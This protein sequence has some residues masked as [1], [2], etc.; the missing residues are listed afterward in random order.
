MSSQKH[1]TSLQ[2]C[3]YLPTIAPNSGLALPD[4]VPVHQHFSTD[5]IEDI[6]QETRTQ[7]ALLSETDLRGKQIAI[8]AGSRGIKG[9]VETLKAIVAQLKAWEAKPF[10]V[11]AMGSHGGATASGQVEVLESLGITENSIGAP[12]RSSMEIVELGK[13]DRNTVVCCDRLAFESDGIIVCNRVKAH[14]GFLGDYESGLLKMMAI[15]L[16]KHIGTTSLH[17]L[18][19][20]QFHRVIPE[21]AALFLEKAPIL[22]GV[23]I[24]E[25][26]HSQTASISGILPH[27]LFKREKELLTIA[28][29]TMG[30]LL[31]SDIDLLVVDEIGKDISGGGM[32]SNITGRAASGIKRPNSPNIKQIVI[33][34]LTHATAGNSLGM[35][36]ADVMTRRAADKINLACTYTNV[37]TSGVPLAGKLPIIAENDRTAIE[38]AHNLCGTNPNSPLRVAHIRNTK[39]L[40][41]I[42][43]STTYLSE[44]ESNPDLSTMGEPRAYEFDD[45]GASLWPT[46]R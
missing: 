13:L 15:G 10:I 37:L 28:K 1:K 46:S 34:D 24:V 23:A 3:E 17:Q 30:R 40:E 7:L 43:L 25:N 6:D 2:F 16:G 41:N 26:A 21:A 33:R 38:M 4:L 19:F 36:M 11:P 45:Q 9:F 35:G 20:G 14:T 29:N 5:R 8:T 22:F 32:D 27:D 18:G 12:I 44:I 31:V 39:D 42:W